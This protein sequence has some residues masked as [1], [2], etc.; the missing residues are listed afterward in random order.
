MRLHEITTEYHNL[1]E[2]RLAGAALAG[3]L[4]LGGQAQASNANY[5]DDDINTLIKQ[6]EDPL[7]SLAQQ[8]SQEHDERLNALDKSKLHNI[9]KI[10]QAEK[11]EGN[12]QQKPVVHPT[13][14]LKK[15]PKPKLIPKPI[16]P[17]VYKPVTGL[18]IE[19]ALHNFAVKLGVKG[20]ELA[21][22]MGQS[23]HES[24]GFKTVKEY[25]SG[26]KYE[27]RR[28]L[29]NIYKGDGVKYKGRGFIQITG[30]A[31]YTEAGKDLNL[32]LVNHPELVETPANAAKVTWWYWQHKVRPHIKNF[33]NTLAV[34]KKVNGGITG[35]KNREK[36]TQNFKLAQK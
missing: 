28:D 30:R 25:A 8:K 16:V 12:A 1:D 34:T 5:Q 26:D 24:D 7:G 33:S 31:N 4:A 35:L 6:K 36:M 11:D 18:A 27:G 2:K 29:G 9:M 17:K 13:K 21:A 22:F 15:T 14:T 20:A 10:M 3:A 23:A 19:T 32:D